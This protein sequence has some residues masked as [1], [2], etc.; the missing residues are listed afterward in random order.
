LVE[1]NGK[2]KIDFSNF[3]VSI[4]FLINLIKPDL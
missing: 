3:G 4:F 1:I 2:I